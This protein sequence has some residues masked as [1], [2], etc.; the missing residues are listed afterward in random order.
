MSTF[1]ED[2]LLINH[3]CPTYTFEAKDY[4]ELIDQIGEA[5]G[6]TSVG[7]SYAKLGPLSGLFAKDAGGRFGVLYTDINDFRNAVS[8]IRRLHPQPQKART[9][10]V[11]QELSF[12]HKD[13]VNGIEKELANRAQ[14]G[15]SFDLGKYKQTCDIDDDG[16]ALPTT[17]VN[18]SVKIMAGLLAGEMAASDIFKKLMV[19]REAYTITE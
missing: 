2:L 5:F 11:P 18:A 7:S 4:D 14:A 10:H 8:F 17:V 12:W 16:R 9:I 15:R 3:L 6:H 13:I 19:I 1:N